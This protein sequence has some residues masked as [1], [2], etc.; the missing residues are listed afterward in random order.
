MVKGAKNKQKN[1]KRKAVKQQQLVNMPPRTT[2]SVEKTLQMRGQKPRTSKRL[3]SV[4]DQAY[5][6]C[7]FDPWKFNTSQGIPDGSSR[8]AIVADSRGYADLTVPANATA[9]ILVFP[10]L[11]T[12]AYIKQGTNVSLPL[13]N[14]GVAFNANQGAGP[15]TDLTSNWLPLL[16]YFET[17]APGN[18]AMLPGISSPNRYTATKARVVTQAYDLIYTGQAF[19]ASGTITARPLRFAQTTSPVYTSVNSNYVDNAGTAGSYPGGTKAIWYDLQTATLPY[20]KE[21]RTFRVEQG[22]CGLLRHDSLKHDWI[23]LSDMPFIVATNKG[24]SILEASTSVTIFGSPVAGVVEGTQNLVDPGW[25]AVLLVISGGAATSSFRLETITCFEYE[26]NPASNFAPLAKPSPK[27]S[28]ASL[29]LAGQIGGS[30]E[31]VRPVADKSSWLGDAMKAAGSV[32]A[33]ALPALMSTMAL[34]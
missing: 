14:N 11:P 21:T 27:P 24:G 7:R 20:N 28:P 13:V 2:E 30:Q 6:Q 25:E 15:S 9:Y 29:A 33:N 12:S 19:S 4:F 3:K 26:L 5:L 18:P 34:V 10:G 8:Q 23:D 31:Y 16:T 17:I 1:G 22:A 32:A